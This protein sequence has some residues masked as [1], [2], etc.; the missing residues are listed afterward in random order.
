MSRPSCFGS[1]M[2]WRLV[3]FPSY[4]EHGTHWPRLVGLGVTRVVA[5]T[6]PVSS[7]QRDYLP[8]F[9]AKANSRLWHGARE[10][11]AGSVLPKM[12]GTCLSVDLT[13][14]R[15][16]YFFFWKLHSTYFLPRIRAHSLTRAPV[17]HT[18][19]P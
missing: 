8:L 17:F 11:L 7:G 18:L 9:R 5:D 16:C 2:F 3:G 13:R 1:G 14:S 12:D 10:S 15:N 6:G 4:L 19:L